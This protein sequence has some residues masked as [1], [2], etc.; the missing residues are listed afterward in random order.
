M[1][2]DE[3]DNSKQHSLVPL[4]PFPS[5]LSYSGKSFS[6]KPSSHLP[7]GSFLPPIFGSYFD[8]SFIEEMAPIESDRI[9]SELITEEVLDIYEELFREEGTFIEEILE[10]ELKQSVIIQEKISKS[11]GSDILLEVIKEY[12][13]VS[14]TDCLDDIIKSHSSEMEMRLSA[15]IYLLDFEKEFIT[16]IVET[17]MDHELYEQ[18][19]SVILEEVIVSETSTVARDVLIHSGAKQAF[20]HYK[21][22]SQFAASLVLDSM[23]LQILLPKPETQKLNFSY[24]LDD[25]IFGILLNK[26]LEL[27]ENTREETCLPILQYHKTL[28]QN[29]LLDMTLDELTKINS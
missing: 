18:E 7:T 26:I 24:I 16:E 3:N 25:L 20:S 27:N 23:C 29:I 22:I 13:Y 14:V 2:S 8:F 4:Y 19:C 11:I 12:C 5:L 15:E 21:Q 10:K 28:L 6:T 17:V 1:A 9:L